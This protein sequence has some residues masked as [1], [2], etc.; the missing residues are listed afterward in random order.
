MLI[1]LLVSL[2]PLHYVLL[3]FDV[4]AVI[5]PYKED[6]YWAQ[7]I[8]KKCQMLYDMHILNI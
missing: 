6:K 8:V 7:S 1:W 2:P 3:G 4:H 5:Y